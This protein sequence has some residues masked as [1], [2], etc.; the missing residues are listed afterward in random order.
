MDINNTLDQALTDLKTLGLASS[1]QFNKLVELFSIDGPLS[2]S[3]KNYVFRPSQLR[4]A[5]A[6]SALMEKN[7]LQF[8]KSLDE[9]TKLIKK[10]TKKIS[11]APHANRDSKEN[12]TLII[13]AGTGT[14]KT[15]AYLIPAILWGGKTIISTGSKH[16]QDQL[17]SK[18]IPNIKKG[19]LI[20][21]T[22][23]LLKGRSNY[24]CLHYLKQTYENGASGSKRDIDQLSKIKNLSEKTNSGDKNDFPNIPEEAVIW[25]KITS[26]KE[27]CLG[28]ECNFYKDCFVMKARRN[29][30]KADIVIVNHHL[31]FSD[32]LLKDTGFA[33]LL[34]KSNTVIFDEAHLLPNVATT[35]FGESISTSQLIDFSCDCMHIYKFDVTKEDWDILHEQL[36]DSTKS[37]RISVGNFSKRISI[38]D[39]LSNNDFSNAVTNIIKIVEKMSEILQS[40]PSNDQI[41]EQY[42]ERACKFKEKLINWKLSYENG[43]LI[44]IKYSSQANPNQKNTEKKQN[45]ISWAE[46]FKH[47]IQLHLTPL[48][49]AEI[50]KK[51]RESY[52]RSWIF[53]SA[54]LAI[55]GTFSHYAQQLGLN[56]HQTLLLPSPFNYQEQALLYV[57]LGIPKPASKNFFEK[58]VKL[59]LPIILANKGHTLILCTT[60]RSV[61]ELSNTYQKELSTINPKF[62]ILSQGKM[63]KFVMLKYF[64]RSTNT[65]LI[66]S[67]S[68]WEGID[69]PG[70]MLSLV[71]IDKLPFDPPDDPITAAKLIQMSDSGQDPFINYQI[72]R[73]VLALKQGVGRLIRLENDKG[74]LI[75]CDQRIV[76][77]PYGKNFWQSLP[78]FRR[79]RDYN[80]AINFAKNLQK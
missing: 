5:I 37:L 16:L 35:F 2:K 23:A 54:T 76:D 7:N 55:K 50:F 42:Y 64:A 48:S 25:Q 28:Q 3:Y 36:L 67:Q 59:T 18:D 68:F 30:Q 38:T 31:F 4:M 43:K 12:S 22:V 78:P 26:T 57:P 40:N 51:K 80:E 15:F 77:M 66:G 65:I 24:L 14:G 69:L 44:K 45:F 58:I 1:K 20:P 21:F 29:A 49:I 73:A 8:N 32:I 46:I 70:K 53:T 52:S 41:I 61:D 79:T 13:E 34:P 60:L 72:P 27:N 17:F 71:I 10:N 75:I 63:N 62:L 6:I 11:Y 47:S 74:L 56:E 39:L 33:E 19:L 9:E